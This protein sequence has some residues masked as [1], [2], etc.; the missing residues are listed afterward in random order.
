MMNLSW[1]KQIEAVGWD[2]DGTLYPAKKELSLEIVNKRYEAVAEKKS[3]S[4]DEAKVLFDEMHKK[5]GSST[6]ALYEFGIDGIEFYTQVWD[7]MDLEKY[8]KGDKKLVEMLDRI[9][10]ELGLTSF[11]ISNSNRLDQIERKLDLIGLSTDEFDLVVST[12]ELGVVKPDPEPFLFALEKLELE[13][14]KVL[15]VGDR[16]T[17]DV[18]GANGVGMRSCLVGRE[19]EEADVCLEFVYEVE[20]FLLEA[21]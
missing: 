21:K 12:V 11:M 8:I 5:A 13:P 10:K 15:F 18:M 3:V 16:V 6:K 14:D 20:S 1:I 4:L 19:S 17:T 9:N 2:L 7:S